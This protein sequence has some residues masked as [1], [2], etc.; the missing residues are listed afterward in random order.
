MTIRLGFTPSV[1]EGWQ[2][3]CLQNAI[4][5]MSEGRDRECLRRVFRKVCCND[6]PSGG[7]GSRASQLNL[8]C[9]QHVLRKLGAFVLV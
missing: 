8:Y 9:V 1:F 6:A 4:L 5:G 7:C 2:N 3:K